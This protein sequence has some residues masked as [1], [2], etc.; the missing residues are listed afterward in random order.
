M[1]TIPSKVAGGGNLSTAQN[2]FRLTF[3]QSLSAAP[4]YQMWDNGST[5]PAVDNLGSTVAKEAFTGTSGNSNKPEYALIATTSS[6][7]TSNWLPS[8]ATSGSHNPNRMKGTTNYV[9]DPTTPTSGQSIRFNIS[10]E[11]ASDSTV[12]STTSQS[13]LLQVVYAYSGSS[14]TLTM[15]FNDVADGGTEVSPQW[16]TMTAGTHGIRLVNV[17]TVSGTYNWT[18]PLGGVGDVEELW[19][20]T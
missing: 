14:P 1:S 4:Q 2:V 7:P 16:A 8:S 10:A 17:G 9:T 6:A 13:V 15:A 11:F 20:T 5:Y 12:P 18:L 19:V 3:S